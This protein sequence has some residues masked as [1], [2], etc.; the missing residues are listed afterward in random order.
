MTG[1]LVRAM[2]ACPQPIIA[3]VEGVCAGAGAIIAMASDLRLAAP[4][5]KTAF[6]FTR[7]GLSAAPTWAPARSCR[8]SSAM[9]APPSC[10][11]PAAAMS[12]EEGERWGFWSRISDDVHGRCAGAGA[13]ARRRPDHRACRDQA[14]AR[15]R[16][17][18]LDRGGDRD[19]G[20]GPG[21]SAC[22]PRISTAPTRPSPPSGSRSSRVTDWLD[23][24]FFEPR[25][26]E[27]AER[28]ER[29]VREHD[30]RRPCRRCRRRLPGAGRRAGQGRLPQAVRGRRRQ[31]ARRPQPGHRPRDARPRPRPG[32]LRLRHAGPRAR[33]RSAC[34]AA[35]RKRPN[36]CRR[37]PAARRSPPMR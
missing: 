13:P 8:G 33:A 31:G 28:L 36:G 34:S 37:S 7:V 11:S 24:P 6:L 25:H 32:R 17:A 29:M 1:D 5:A 3:A 14:A 30:P 35:T 2:R 12:A 22:R 18:C 21:R 20:R 27:L 16:M 26:R 4:D 23:W 9:A 19:G 10:C 15:C